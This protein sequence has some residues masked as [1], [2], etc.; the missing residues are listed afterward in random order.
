MTC[1]SECQSITCVVFD[2]Q[3][4]NNFIFMENRVEISVFFPN[5]ASNSNKQ[6]NKQLYVYLFWKGNWKNRKLE[7]VSK[8]YF[9]SRYS[10]TEGSLQISEKKKSLLE[11]ILANDDI[12]DSDND[13]NDYD[14]NCN[15]DVLCWWW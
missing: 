5:L 15:D 2:I 12:T 10:V 9:L 11:V 7:K 1:Y 8:N 4:W 13:A 6:A 14:D 3:K